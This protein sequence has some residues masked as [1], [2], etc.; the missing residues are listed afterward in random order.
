[1]PPYIEN[2]IYN[3]GGSSVGGGDALAQQ[4]GNNQHQQQ[5]LSNNGAIAR[6]IDAADFQS[7]LN[8]SMF[9]S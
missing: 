4:K 5:L 9:P 6:N 2:D 7:H 8:K 1:M 3:G